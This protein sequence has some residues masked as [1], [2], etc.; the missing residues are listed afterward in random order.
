M[1]VVIII[2]CYTVLDDIAFDIKFKKKLIK[3]RSMKFIQLLLV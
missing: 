3:N 2:Y 1:V